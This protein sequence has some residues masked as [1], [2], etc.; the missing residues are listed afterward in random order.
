MKNLKVLINS[1]MVLARGGGGG[2][3]YHRLTRAS[4]AFVALTWPRAR[5]AASRT[6]LSLDFRHFFRLTI[7][8]MSLEPVL[9]REMMATACMLTSVSVKRSIR[10]WITVALLYLPSMNEN[11]LKYHKAF[12][13]MYMTKVLYIW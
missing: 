4:T 8:V 6:T 12:L 10:A 3:T 13:I 11:M 2:L 9:A 5:Q 1:F 7:V